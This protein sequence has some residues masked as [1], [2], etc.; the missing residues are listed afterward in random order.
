VAELL[1]HPQLLG[2]MAATRVFHYTT[3]T[4]FVVAVV[5]VH[6]TAQVP[7]ATSKVAQTRRGKTSTCLERPLRLQATILLGALCPHLSGRGT[8]AKDL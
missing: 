1:Q 2:R 5:V 4:M 8:M 3:L 7:R 6:V